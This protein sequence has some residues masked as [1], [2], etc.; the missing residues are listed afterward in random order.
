M[1][2]SSDITS[3]TEH[4]TKLKEHLR[5]VKETGRPMFITSDGQPVAVVL[6]PDAYDALADTAELARSEAMVAKSVADIDAGRTEPAK[7]AIEGI[8]AGL[9]LHVKRNPARK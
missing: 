4:R 6:S 8:A 3:V 2:R 5:Q 1:A 7:S 9:S